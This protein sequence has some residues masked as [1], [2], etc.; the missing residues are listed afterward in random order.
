MAKLDMDKAYNQ[1]SWKF[2]YH[3]L[4]CF[5]FHDQWIN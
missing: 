3:A 2:L 4:K 1:I 5:G